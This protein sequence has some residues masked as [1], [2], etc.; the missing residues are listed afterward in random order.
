[1]RLGAEVPPARHPLPPPDPA[2]LSCPRPPRRLAGPIA[3]LVAGLLA[4]AAP[5]LPASAADR[6]APADAA[7]TAR[8]RGVLSELRL[9]LLAHDPGSPERGSADVAVQVF[10]ER[11]FA[12]PGF[13]RFAV[14]R[15]LIGGSLNTAG[16]TSH[17]H[18]GLGWTVDLGATVFVEG[19]LGVAIHDGPPGRAA[20]A[21]R[22]ALGCAA[23]MRESAGIGYRLDRHWSLTASVEHLSN[24]GLCGRNRGLTSYGLLLGYRF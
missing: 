17:L 5:A 16:K 6:V 10:L 14:P 7:E 11:P 9:G 1:M 15:P 23:L 3:R 19:A 20:P 13:W 8:A 2:A 4:M 21:G 24:G 12:A 18:A 22:S